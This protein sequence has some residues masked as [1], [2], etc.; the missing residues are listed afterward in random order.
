MRAGEVGD[1]PETGLAHG[2]LHVIGDDPQVTGE[3]ELEPG[4]DRMAL[5]SGDGDQV[6]TAPPGE[7]LLVF[8]DGR[9]ERGIVTACQIE[10]GRLSVETLR[11][12]RLPVQ[13]GGEG[14]ALTAQHHDADTAR[15]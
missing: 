10:E 9:V 12:E 11:R 1:E 5:D 8:G 3:G 13:A 4:T 7:R 2:E 15:Q 6:G 14:L